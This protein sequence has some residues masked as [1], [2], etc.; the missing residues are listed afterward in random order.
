MNW[1]RKLGSR[2]SEWWFGDNSLWNKLAPNEQTLSVGGVSLGTVRKS[3]DNNNTTII[4][5]MQIPQGLKDFFNNPD[6]KKALPYLIGFA[7]IRR[8]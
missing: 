3:P 2:S 4:E 5:G 1:F 8:L 6:V 7:I